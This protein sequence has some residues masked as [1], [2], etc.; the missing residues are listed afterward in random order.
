MASP[1]CVL[2]VRPNASFKGGGKSY[3]WRTNAS[4]WNERVTVRIAA[5]RHTRIPCPTK[6]RRKV[7]L[8]TTVCLGLCTITVTVS[9]STCGSC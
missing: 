8:A 4:S 6:T 2:M 9:V 1:R 3:L 7:A 5:D